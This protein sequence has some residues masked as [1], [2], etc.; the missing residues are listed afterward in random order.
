MPRTIALVGIIGTQIRANYATSVTNQCKN[1]TPRKHPSTFPNSEFEI[2][3][4]THL[5]RLLNAWS[6][7]ESRL[8]APT[9]TISSRSSQPSNM[10]LHP[11]PIQAYAITFK[12]Y[13]YHYCFGAYLKNTHT[14]LKLLGVS[15]LQAFSVKTFS[16][17]RF[18]HSL[19]VT[20]KNTRLF[21]Q[22]CR[23]KKISR[24][25]INYN[26]ARIYGYGRFQE[27]IEGI[28]L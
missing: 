17:E 1:Y 18:I 4:R 13:W 25:V 15:T 23:R 5:V 10:P 24:Y 11:S 6:Q 3:L 8:S 19:V 20:H 21:F 9:Y 28:T 16:L 26:L 7:K 12:T 14:V 2:S 27:G 22:D